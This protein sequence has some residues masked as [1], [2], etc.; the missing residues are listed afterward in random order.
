M[1]KQRKDNVVMA[2]STSVLYQ[3]KITD[4]MKIDFVTTPIKTLDGYFQCV[5][6]GNTRYIPFYL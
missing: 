6:K 2:K 3:R 5:V 1:L 4:S